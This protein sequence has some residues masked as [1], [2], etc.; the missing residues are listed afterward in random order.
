[1]K[2][3]FGMMAVAAALLTG[4]SAYNAQNGTGITNV[5]L[6]N[7]EAL[8]TPDINYNVPQKNNNPEE[9]TLYVAVD[10]KVYTDEKSIGAGI[11]YSQVPGIVN[12]CE[13]PPKN[14]TATGCDP[15]NCH[16]RVS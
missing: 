9:C 8:A 16:Q 11:S 6:A 3:L 7:V 4:Y 1:M 2:K 10:G 13:F 12:V 5:A 14:Q 15:Y